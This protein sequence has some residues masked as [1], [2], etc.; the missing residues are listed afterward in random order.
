MNTQ[1]ERDFSIGLVIPTLGLRPEYLLDALHSARESGAAHI[2]LVCPENLPELERLIERALIDSYVVDPG[3]GA[4]TAIDLGIRSLPSEMEY[5]SWLGDDDLLEPG[6][7]KRLADALSSSPSSVTA[8]GECLFIDS[9]GAIFGKSSFG[10]VASA[11]LKFGPDLVPQPASLVRTTAYLAIGG[12]DT[13]LKLAFDLDMF[14]K[15]SK[16]GKI[17]HVPFVA[18]RYRWH[19]GSLSS[20]N[21]RASRIESRAVRISHLPGVFRPLSFIWEAPMEIFAILANTLDRKSGAQAK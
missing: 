6:S 12:L 5:V 9:N 1:S 13:R 15:L 11:L 8:F 18:A 3:N 20:A 4:A 10:K 17:I 7:L 19:A 21:K 14:I 2:V 16:V